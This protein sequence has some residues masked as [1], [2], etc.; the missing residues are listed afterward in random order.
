[1]KTIVFTVFQRGWNIRIQQIFHSKIINKH[2]CNPNMFFDTSNHRK[3]RKVSQIG[4]QWGTQNP[5]KIKK[6]H[7]G[8]LQGPPECICA[9]PDH[10]NGVK[11]I[12]KDLHMDPKCSPEDPKRTSKSTTSNNQ[13]YDK[14]M[15]FHVYQLISILQTSFSIPGNPFSC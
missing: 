4:L 15:F 8:T 2:A 7:V 11:I 12:S 3:H 6:I 5:S 14:R 9:P 13:V 10:Q 1:M